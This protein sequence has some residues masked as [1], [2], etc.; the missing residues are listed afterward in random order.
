MV[1]NA[2]KCLDLGLKNQIIMSAM[3]KMS[4]TEKCY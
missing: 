1:L 4:S 2:A 3:A